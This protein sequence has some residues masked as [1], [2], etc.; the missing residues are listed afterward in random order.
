MTDATI[1]DNMG[2]AIQEMRCHLEETELAIFAKDQATA[3]QKAFALRCAFNDALDAW[4][5]LLIAQAKPA[6][7][8]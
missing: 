1:V 8:I 5:E 7:T 3:A 2:R 6:P 4:S